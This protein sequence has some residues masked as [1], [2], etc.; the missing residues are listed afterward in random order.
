MSKL[1]NLSIIMPCYKGESYI[2]ESI[3]TVEREICSTTKDFELIVVIDGFID[4]GYE[5][6]KNLEKEY[7]NLIVT[8]YEKNRGKGH[9]LLQGFKKCRGKHIAFLDSDMDYDPKALKWFLDI[10]LY[11]DADLVIGNRKDKKS[12]YVYP[13]V[14]KISSWAFNRFVKIIFP[15]IE[16]PDTQAGIK[17]MK[18]ML[19]E[20]YFEDVE[21]Q[22]DLQGFILDIF[23]LLTAKKANMKIVSSYCI[24]DM[25]S[26]TIGTGGNLIKTAY[27]MGR[28]VLTLKRRCKYEVNS[29]E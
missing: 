16:Y 1:V 19:A 23:L 25:K 2:V 11:Q 24:F 28:E 15:E 18:R 4:K 27:R 7:E 29:I 9:A 14:R 8:G 17:L 5:Y 22:P 6:A 12:T 10:V 21:K 13:M 26:S 3:K 20:K